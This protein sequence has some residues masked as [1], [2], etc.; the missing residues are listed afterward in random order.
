MRKKPERRLFSF[1]DIIIVG[2]VVAVILLT[3]VFSLFSVSSAFAD[4]YIKGKLY[5]TVPLSVNARYALTADPAV[6]VGVYNRQLS[7]KSADRKDA[8]NRFRNL[9]KKGQKA[10][11]ISS[12]VTVILTG[13]DEKPDAVTY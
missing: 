4:I 2:I 6:T 3:F 8:D 9:S 5:R 10:V 7:L 12:G 1:F 11:S 13:G